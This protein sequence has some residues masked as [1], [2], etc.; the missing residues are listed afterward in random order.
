[1]TVKPMTVD[2]G[3]SAGGL[4]ASE[5]GLGGF[6][7][8]ADGPQ[9]RSANGESGALEIL[10]LVP[11]NESVAI[12]HDAELGVLRVRVGQVELDAEGFWIPIVLLRRRDTIDVVATTN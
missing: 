11:P 7:S 4:V 10:E 1:M 3:S 9:L 2:A 5:G 8:F 6:D 12:V